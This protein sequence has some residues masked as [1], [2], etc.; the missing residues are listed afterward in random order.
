MEEEITK[1]VETGAAWGFDF[2]GNEEE[3]YKVVSAREREDEAR[4]S[5]QV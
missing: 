2:N 3:I 1:V 4:L 5:G